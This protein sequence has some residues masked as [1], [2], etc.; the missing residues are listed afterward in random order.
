MWE[1]LINTWCLLPTAWWLLSYVWETLFNTWCLLPTA[2]W[3]L[4]YV[5]ETLFNTWCLLPNAWWLLSYVWETLFNTWCQLPNA[6]WLLH[7]MLNVY[8]IVK[9][10]R[11]YQEHDA[12]AWR[13]KLFMSIQGWKF[14]HLLIAYSLICSFRS[15]RLSN[16]ERFA[17]IAQDKWVTVSELLRLLRGN[18]QPWANH[19][20]RSRQMSDPEWFA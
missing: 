1:T 4:S 2:W 20:G 5:W 6:W 11:H 16:C 9:V 13:N 15:N 17:Q 10:W 12:S 14:A 8:Y 7:L 18:E 3:L 19:S